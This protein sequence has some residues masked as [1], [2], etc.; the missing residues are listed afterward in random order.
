ML[1]RISEFFQI[2][3]NTPNER[4]FYMIKK[5][6]RIIAILLI[7]G[8][9]LS[10][11]PPSAAAVAI[12]GG[13]AESA[14][15]N[16]QDGYEAYSE[17]NKGC[18]NA[19]S[20]IKITVSEPLWN[21][22]G[23][24]TVP[25]TVTESGL[26]NM[27]IVWQ[28]QKSGTDIE[29][30]IKLDG[31]Y[32]FSE[33]ANC[34]LVR[35]WK[36]AEETPRTDSQG[37]EYAQEQTEIGGNTETVIRDR[38][39][40]I[41]E[42]YAFYLE[43]GKHTV[44]FADAG[45]PI[46]V[47]EVVFCPPYEAKPYA[48][49]FK[50]NNAENNGG[51]IITVQAENADIKTSKSIIPKSDNSNAGMTPSDPY[52]AK[53]NY[54]GGTTWQI[55][56]E[57]LTWKFNV[58]TAGYYTLTVRYMQS[59]VING[60][61]HRILRVNGETPFKEADDLVFGYCTKWKYWTFKDGNGEPYSIW[62]DSGENTLSLEA[63]VGSQADYYYRLNDIV[64]TL[65]DKYIHIV[66]ITGETPDANR[67]YNL[68]SQIPDFTEKLTDAKNGLNK[69]ASDMKKAYGT[70]STQFIASIENASRV[71]NNMLDNPYGAHL[72][73]SDYYDSY[74]T[75]SSWLHDMNNMPLCL[76]EIQLVPFGKD[77][78][79]KNADFFTQQYYNIVRFISSFSNDYK[80]A[81]KTNEDGEREIKLWVTWGQDQAS[82]LESLIKESFTYKTGIK[83][84][85]QIVNTSLINGLLTGNF[86][87]VALMQART[88][89]VNLGMRGAVAD[90]TQFSDCE[91]VLER[92]AEGADIPY[93]YNGGLYAL[94]DTQS[95]FIMFARTD[96]LESL[97]L[98][99]PKTWDEFIHAT[100]IIQRNN[101]NV[102]LPYTQMGNASSV[103]GGLGSLH[104]FSTLM[105]Q[106][107]LSIYNKEGTATDI[108]NDKAVDV[109]K[110]W[111][112]FYKEY[113]VLKSADF[114][115]RFRSGT[116]P[117]GIAPYTTYMTLY[118]AA[119]EI[120]GRW[121]IATV[122]GTDGGNNTV[123]GGGTGCSIIEK[124]PDKSAAWEFLKWWTSA[125]TQSRYIGNVESLLGTISRP[126][127]S[128]VEAFNSLGWD[129][130]D[131]KVLN[132]QWSLVRELPEVPGS[133]YLIRAVDQA[134]W[135]VVNGEAT[136]RDAL[137]KWSRV[138]DGEI[139]RKIKEYS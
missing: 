131:L 74:T 32:P 73:L 87:D 126:T 43:K 122:P 23:E 62:L 53:I 31:K 40:I 4:I 118:S 57:T 97:G 104:L 123:A 3:T 44:S 116:M 50:A 83:V 35:L 69:L 17:R 16:V 71:L 47:Y 77:F 85:M 127:T 90:L 110:Y 37:N 60:E 111:T 49:V 15:A 117:L 22:E 129:S 125:D 14:F 107:R 12:N 121:K 134:F 103:S 52:K 86:P 33:S 101:M 46:S 1:T 64:K 124:S 120:K 95:F 106:T 34:E 38:S 80:K 48:D 7:M 72:Y 130:S 108:I 10:S 137:V 81:E 133:Y 51:R 18:E 20:E 75:L 76:D 93:R 99:I 58:E 27:K 138:A 21:G 112:D 59:D 8:V 139:S 96:I 98:E 36:N 113:S 88:E 79:N 56:G 84:N 70:R 66:M 114:Y 115:N 19:E 42:P 30:G 102:Y 94:P 109:F 2:A 82:A 28:P 55:P 132:E 68:F 25:F 92:F 128:N 6:I 54:I 105:S 39:A 91:E 45:Q 41:A 13:I 89:P 136:A 11:T 119:P 67:D 61:S 29:L 63:S 78:E 65:G 9:L 135:T 24:F 5:E 26:Y 100:T